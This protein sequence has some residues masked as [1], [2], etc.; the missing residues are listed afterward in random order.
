L[1]SI[2]HLQI[3]L[4]EIATLARRPTALNEAEGRLVALIEGLT[5]VEL[6]ESESLIQQVTP[7]PGRS[8]TKCP[9]RISRWAPCSHH[10]PRFGRSRPPSP[11]PWRPPPTMR[12][13]REATGPRT[14][15]R[16]CGPT[17]GSRCTGATW[18]DRGPRLASTFLPDHPAWAGHLLA[19]DRETAGPPAIRGTGAD[20]LNQGPLH[21]RLHRRSDRLTWRRTR[22]G[23]RPRAGAPPNLR[24]CAQETGRSRAARSRGGAGANP[25]RHCVHPSPG[26][27]VSA[28]LEFPVL[29]DSAIKIAFDSWRDADGN[30][31]IYVM[32][33][34]GTAQVRLTHS[35]GWDIRPV[36]SPDG[37][38]LAFES[39]RDGSYE[40]PRDER[41]RHG[42]AEP[43]RQ[44]VVVLTARRPGRPAAPSS[45]LSRSGTAMLRST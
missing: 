17:C 14:S 34:D 8:R 45:P 38:K 35:Q 33:E 2:D 6:A 22:L 19:C 31:E 4:G 40:G 43:Q 39:T 28:S 32:T 21:R 16:M 30:G 1:P 27:G 36:W 13:W 23:G 29:P 18:T 37:P 26:G 15:T 3:A 9:R 10:S 20:L 12:A 5:P 42:P 41:Q 24:E 44:L 11:P 7:R 25:P